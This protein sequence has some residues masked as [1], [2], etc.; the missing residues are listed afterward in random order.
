MGHNSPMHQHKRQG[1]TLVLGSGGARGLA[2]VGVLRALEEMQ[3]PIAAVVGCSIGAQ[4]GALYCAGIPVA[5]L[6]MEAQGM[7]WW[8][9]LRLFFPDFGG[10]G[11]SSGGAIEGYLRQRLG[12][13]DIQDFA[14]PFACVATDLVAGREVVLTEGPALAAV[15]ASIALPVVLSPQR[16][17]GRILADGGLV[18][19]VPVV[20]ARALFPGPLL[21]VL[22]HVATQHDEPW[23]PRDNGMLPRINLFNR[24]DDWVADL[25]YPN[26]VQTMRRAVEI[27]QGRIVEMQLQTSPADLTLQPKLGN[28]LT[29]EFHK[30]EAAV[31][32]GYRAAREATAAIM[33]LLQRE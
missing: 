33:A 16:L 10:G 5:D 7:R 3:V 30:G 4:I 19:P 21:A 31:A 13:R 26:L 2:H 20:V 25:P 32:A 17:G 11:L 12:D 18:D 24:G 8:E 28:I 14:T 9:A 23:P 15:R 1:I 29:L 27:M 6:E 22:V